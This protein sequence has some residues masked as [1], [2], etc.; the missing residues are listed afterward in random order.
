MSLFLL[1]GPASAGEAT[2]ETWRLLD[3]PALWV[4]ALV[5][6]PG[7][8]LIAALGY[9]REDLKG[10]SRWT[11]ISLRFLS[12]LLLAIVL[13]RPVRVKQQENI[14]PAEVIVLLDDSAS[15][16]R[17]DAY[18]G[19]ESQRAA[20]RRLGGKIAEETT[21]LELAKA[22]LRDLSSH[23]AGKDYEVH[24][25]R[26]DERL[27]ALPDPDQAEGRGH[28]THLGDALA[29]ALNSKGPGHLT[30]VVVLTDGRSTGGQDVLEVAA[31]AR[32][33]GIPIHTLVVGDTREERNLVVELVEAPPSVLEGDQISV[34]VRIHARGVTD[35]RQVSVVLEELPPPGSRDEPRI[36]STETADVSDVGDR[37]VLVAPGE[38]TGLEA[39][40]RRFR[41]SVAPLPDERMTDDN[42][43][44][45]SV[46]V[47]RERVRVLYV[48]GYPRWEYRFLKDLLLRADERIVVQVYLMSATS[49]FPQEATDGID[50]LERVPTERRELLDNYDV[51]VLGDVNPYAVSPDPAEG[52]R[53]VQ[54]LVEFVERGGGLAV[55]A[56][57]YE[58]P[59]ALA[60]TEF[61]KLLPVELD[62]TGSLGFDQTTEIERRPLLEH[63]A[64]PHE[65]V[66]LHP[67]DELNRELWEDDSGLRG[68]YWYYPVVKAKPGAQVLLRHS[69]RSLAGDDQ[70]DPLLVVGYYPSG[71]TMFLATD[72]MTWRW[73][74]RYVHRYHE[75][76]WRNAIRWLALGRLKGGD[77]RFGL[78]PLRTSY[79]LDERVTLEARVLD[80][81][82]RPSD[83]EDQSIYLQG[84]D[85]PPE[86]LSLGGIDGRPG[87]FRGTFQ[88]ERPGLYR[89]WIEKD[90]ERLATTE[91]EVVLPSRE[92]ADPSPDP[93]TLKAISQLTQGT[94]ARVTEV[95]RLLP[96]FPG[97]EELREPISSQ[98]E[99]A[100]DQLSTLLLALGLLS[101]EWILRKRHELV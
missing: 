60:G 66:R 71:R 16:R 39:S 17:R 86:E 68:Y 91:V 75:R 40:E 26:F 80:E 33:A 52:E 41:V 92:N 11:M 64:N 7:A 62:P 5:V 95:T 47:T 58:N 88:A 69:E 100:W 73:R 98:L 34:A 36:I 63:P 8:A 15:M 9:W 101:V 54:A 61:A 77:R 19:D 4:I 90:G 20:V 89:A 12:L 29:A 23:L 74:Y 48:D 59:R 50:R 1:Q 57:E 13:M 79:G 49:D 10:W 31:T 28:G 51:V 72:D 93:A 25:M 27:S 87:I 24:R 83:Q 46:H 35:Q 55:L 53:F 81:D 45:L 14:V 22:A 44:E 82:Y 37:V 78:E 97:D 38:S 21:R 85:G 65:I 18:T 2:R 42:S 67:N 84:P 32:A 70:R 99:D 6:V 30:D 96:E 3:V 94:H 76:F 56:G 43:L